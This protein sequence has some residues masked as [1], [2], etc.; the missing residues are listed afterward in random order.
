MAYYHKLV[1]RDSYDE[2]CRVTA[3]ILE[4]LWLE[5]LTSEHFQN[6]DGALIMIAKIDEQGCW[7]G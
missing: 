5:G 2:G 6:T 3:K 4:R 1:Y 7:P